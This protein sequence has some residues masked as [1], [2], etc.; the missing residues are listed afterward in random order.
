MWTSTTCF[1]CGLFATSVLCSARR[2]MYVLD[3]CQLEPTHVHSNQSF[4]RMKLLI[5]TVPASVLQVPR[6]A[7]P[8]ISTLISMY[9]SKV[10]AP[11]CSP[12]SVAPKPITMQ[13]TVANVG[14][15]L[16]QSPQSDDSHQGWVSSLLGVR[17][18]N[19]L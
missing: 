1:S 14:C 13:P 15:L 6:I 7:G 4:L 17:I 2:H 11:A 16:I 19:C 5:P 12:A 9:V 3:V 8:I 10:S 18:V